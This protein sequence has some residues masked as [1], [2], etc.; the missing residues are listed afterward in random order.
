MVSL[1]QLTFK[2]SIN[3][4]PYYYGTPGRIATYEGQ[5]F[6][7]VAG[8]WFVPEEGCENPFDIDSLIMKYSISFKNGKRHG[9]SKEFFD[10]GEIKTKTHYRNGLKD[11]RCI[12]F[13]ENGNILHRTSWKDNKLDGLNEWFY[14]TSLRAKGFYE[15]YLTSQTIKE[16]VGKFSANTTIARKTGET[17]YLDEDHLRKM[18]GPGFEG[19]T[20]RL[21]KYKKRSHF[22]NG[23]PIGLQETF[24]P[25]GN[26]KSRAFYSNGAKTGCE[27]KFFDRSVSTSSWAYLYTNDDGLE[28]PLFRK[29]TSIY[30]TNHSRLLS[31]PFNKVIEIGDIDA[32]EEAIGV[33]I[34]VEEE[35][36]GYN[37]SIIL[38]GPTK[39]TT[40]YVGGIRHGDHEVFRSTGQLSYKSTYQNGYLEGLAVSFDEEGFIAETHNHELGKLLSHDI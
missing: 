1:S 33:E 24:Y 14:E 29:I 18:F 9:N 40:Q 28:A 23:V 2:G 11:G 16:C 21:A 4:D 35:L 5:P 12:G 38:P 25:S 3:C 10:S 8:K 37:A 19:K 15:H 13:S 36:S 34:F 22:Q 7:G 32:N 17:Y 30:S 26:L 27:R 20:F 6:T 31:N 39:S